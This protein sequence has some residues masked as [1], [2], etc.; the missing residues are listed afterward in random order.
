VVDDDLL[1]HQTS[2]MSV[3]R[4]WCRRDEANVMEMD[5]TMGKHEVS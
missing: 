4:H 5:I 2:A 3:A 1:I